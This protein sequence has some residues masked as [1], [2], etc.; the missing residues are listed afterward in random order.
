MVGFRQYECPKD[1]GYHRG[2]KRKKLRQIKEGRETHRKE[3][4]G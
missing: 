4:D 2:K 1:G 3:T